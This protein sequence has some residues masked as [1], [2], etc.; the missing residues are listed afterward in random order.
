MTCRGRAAPAS[1][2]GQCRGD[3][4]TIAAASFA[5]APSRSATPEHIDST[6]GNPRDGRRSF[7]ARRIQVYDEIT[8]SS[9]DIAVWVGP[10]EDEAAPKKVSVHLGVVD[11]RCGRCEVTVAMG[12]AEARQI[13]LALTDAAET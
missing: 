8:S 5:V 9:A 13:G 10:G 12:P 3:D 7:A 1:G 4:M 6:S 11:H 2:R